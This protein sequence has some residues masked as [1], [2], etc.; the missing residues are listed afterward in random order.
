M[1][2]KMIYK[3]NANNDNNLNNINREQVSYEER[4][5]I[6]LE[7]N[8]NRKEAAE[9][10][11]AKEFR[12]LGPVSLIYAL[13]LT[14][15]LYKNYSGITNVIWAAATV[16]YMVYVAKKMEK[17]WCL[18]NIFISSI[19]VLL[20]ISNFTTGNATII[21]FN[22][23]AII[24]LIAINM[25]YLF[26]D[27][28]KVNVTNHLLVLT[29][30]V[31]GILLEIGAPFRQMKA[32]LKKCKIRKTDKVVYVLIGIV[33]AVPL[34]LVMLGILSSADSVFG[35]MV[36]DLWE[37][38]SLNT[39]MHNFVGILAMFVAAYFIPYAFT[40]YINNGK[41]SAK[42]GNCAEKEPIVA[43]IVT[44]AVSM[45]YVLFSAVQIIYLFMGKGTLPSDYTYAEYAREGFFQL[46]F[47]SVFNAMMI[48]GCI[49]FFRNSKVLKV[50]LT[51]VSGCT[52]IMIA[53]SAYRMAMYIGEYG[54]TFTRVLVLWA[55]IVIALIM[56][57]LMFKLLNGTFNLF[58]YG[59]VVIAVCFTMLSLSHM[60]YFIA[61]YN[62]NMY[63]EMKGM[64]EDDLYG[65]NNYVDYDYLM[66]LSTDAAPEMAE[67]I[68]EI[69]E[70]ME[71]LKYEL[72][73]PRWTYEEY[74]E[75]E[76]EYNKITLRN[77]NVSRYIARLSM[78]DVKLK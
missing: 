25:M 34:L 15:C 59:T 42:E 51:I 14:F 39:L 38:L 5:R 24:C 61:K 8:K 67:H 47:V 37:M 45:L 13:I 58:K 65:T 32:F 48:L 23:V 66:G 62:L 53:S 26:F 28:K 55:L 22:Y 49:E 29:Q 9:K 77:F 44:G 10:K 70:Y 35:N 12:I 73:E 4:I 21:F 31:L 1:E 78:K 46:L 17:K 16:V 54:L 36:N 43:I 11:D 64:H 50:I 69:C 6:Q 2:N 18:I 72:D 60:D 52:F 68:E 63:E 3:S 30:V 76:E 7:E 57:G 40:K 27:L 19:I 20:G 74:D 33:I 71:G 56:I 41:I 75:I